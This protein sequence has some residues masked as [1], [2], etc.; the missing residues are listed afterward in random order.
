MPTAKPEGSGLPGDSPRNRRSISLADIADGLPDLHWFHRS[1]RTLAESRFQVE[2][3]GHLNPLRP[4]ALQVV[5]Q[6]GLEWLYRQTDE[7]LR[8]SPVFAGDQAYALLLSDGQKP[9]PIVQQV[10]EDRDIALLRSSASGRSIN[11]HLKKKLSRVLSPRCNKHGVFVAVMN[12]GVLIT[13]A[14][15]V[16]KSEV[17]LDLVQR[18]HQLIADDAV[19]LT[20]TDGAMLTGSCE[21]ALKGY[22]EIRGLGIIDIEK[23]FGPA[24]ILD[25]YPLQLIIN[26]RDATN[27]EIRDLDRLQP[28]LDTIEILGVNISQLNMLVAPG[29]NLSVLVEAATRD[30]LLRRSGTDSS[31]EF[32]SRHDRLMDEKAGMQPGVD[33]TK[34]REAR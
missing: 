10:C 20:R 30:H 16:G 33:S 1:E 22:L 21:P 19:S 11:I 23:L 6:L 4:T 27:R 34:T 17:A 15:G 8:A 29:R 24:A 13:G 18:G 14:S 2:L 25:E 31:M 5:D 12:T 9:N 32:L 26:L 28:S 3:F 7:E